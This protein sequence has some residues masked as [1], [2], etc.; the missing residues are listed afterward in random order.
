[1]DDHYHY[2]DNIDYGLRLAQAQGNQSD[3]ATALATLNNI[4][5]TNISQAD[6][7][8]LDLAVAQTQL[9]VSGFRESTLTAYPG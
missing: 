8:R 9:Q 4:H 3:P 7:A 2:P 6:A 5:R 1:M